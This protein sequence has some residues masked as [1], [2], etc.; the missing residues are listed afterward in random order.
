MARGLFC[1][2]IIY[3]LIIQW[4]FGEA[5]RI[6]H[7]VGIKQIGDFLENWDIREKNEDLWLFQ[8]PF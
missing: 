8:G 5:Y 2:G 6:G 7:K 4:D 1:E 3:N